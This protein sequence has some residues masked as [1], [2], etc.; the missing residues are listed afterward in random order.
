MN[1]E[2]YTPTMV[3]AMKTICYMR[4][5]TGNK[6][7]V[8][9]EVER[10]SAEFSDDKKPVTRQNW[11]GLKAN[12]TWKAIHRAIQGKLPP[13]HPVE[14]MISSYAEDDKAG[15][16]L[17]R[18]QKIA[19][20]RAD[21]EEKLKEAEVRYKE[22]VN[23]TLVKR[24]AEDHYHVNY[25]AN[26]KRLA[27]LELEVA[28]KEKAYQAATAEA[29]TL[30]AENK[31]FEKQAGAMG[32]VEKA[33]H[34]LFVPQISDLVDVPDHELL[35]LYQDLVPEAFHKMLTV[36]EKS[37]RPNDVVFIFHAFNVDVPTFVQDSVPFRHEDGNVV[38]A[39]FQ[40]N[41]EKRRSFYEQVAERLAPFKPRVIIVTGGTR[42]PSDL[43]RDD[44]V[45][46]IKPE[47]ASLNERL[48]NLSIRY[49]MD[50][51]VIPEGYDEVKIVRV[52]NG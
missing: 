22:L 18:A 20:E 46:P 11:C 1:P 2:H 16:F 29:D 23:K 40:P 4:K 12:V 24:Y 36:F 8:G 15:I 45:R 5:D 38:F 28:A 51:E 35:Q 19:A 33:R 42:K 44:K 32:A 10:I 6:K 34:R 21:M 31:R 25:E 47:L 41:G 7:L 3:A 30:R 50:Y 52:T 43:A 49:P 14:L 39:C 37:P 48:Q 26:K 13:D 17:A 9:T 27:D